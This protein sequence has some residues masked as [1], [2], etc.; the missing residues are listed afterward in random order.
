M[1]RRGS[2]EWE[3]LKT[4][5]SV[6]LLGRFQT[7]GRGP[8]SLGFPDK[9]SLVKVLGSFQGWSRPCSPAEERFLQAI[10]EGQGREIRL[11]ALVL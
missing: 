9:S 3:F 1:F 2:P 7:D 8:V 4:R 6:S 10:Q 11:L 5:I